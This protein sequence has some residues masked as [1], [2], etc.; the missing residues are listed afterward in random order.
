[1]NEIDRRSFLKSATTASLASGALAGGTLAAQAAGA[2]A[3]TIPDKPTFFKAVKWGMIDEKLSVEGK[4]KLL[5]DLGF[6]GVELDSPGGVNKQEAFEAS[7]KTGLPIHG[8]V[9]STHWRIRL[10]DP[11]P[12]V[13]AH[14]LRDLQT[15]IR[16]SH[17]CGGCAVLLVPGHGKDGTQEE[18]AARS[19]AQIQKA[20]SLAAK[21]GVLILIENVWN[22]FLYQHDGPGNQTADKLAEFIDRANSPWVGSYFDIG[23]HRRYGVPSQWIRRLGHRIRKVDVKDYNHKT[24]QWAEIGEGTVDWANVR[25]ELAKLNYHGWA[26]AEVRGGDRKRLKVIKAQM[27]RVLG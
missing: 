16:E 27:D 18:V 21:L 22:H 10:S 14:A 2:P 15:A 17:Y 24:R 1:M 20:L 6:D 7:R 9:D 23:N 19:L 26:T 4:F 3:K 8:V 13:R 11:D 12:S 25:A 5:Q